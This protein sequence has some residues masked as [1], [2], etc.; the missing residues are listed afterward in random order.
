LDLRRF[1]LCIARFSPLRVLWEAQEPTV[2][3][4]PLAAMQQG[5][6]REFGGWLEFARHGKQMAGDG[7]WY[8]AFL[9]A[10]SEMVSGHYPELLRGDSVQGALDSFGDASYFF[11]ALGGRDEV[12]MP[13]YWREQG[14]DLHLALLMERDRRLQ[15][16]LVDAFEPEPGTEGEIAE[17]I[18]RWRKE[19]PVP[20]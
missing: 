18:I 1:R 12:P 8:L 5:G 10:T 9:L 2:E 20:G 7:I 16:Q 14:I 15:V 13:E 19:N 6:G 3:A 11:A 17:Q 4:T